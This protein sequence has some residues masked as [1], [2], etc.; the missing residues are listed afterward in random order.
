MIEPIKPL[1]LIKIEYYHVR[2]IRKNISD[3]LLELDLNESVLVENIVH[4]YINGDK[5]FCNNTVVDPFDIEA[6]KINRTAVPP[7]LLLLG[8]RNRREAQRRSSRV[9]IVGIPDEWYV[10]EEG[11]HVTRQFIKTPP[12]HSATLNQKQ[13]TV[14]DTKKVFIVHGP[15]DAAKLE[16][17]RIIEG[18]RLKPIILHEQA[19][20]G[21]TLIEKFEKRIE[22]IGYAFILL[23]PDDI[24]KD[25]TAEMYRARQNV[26]LELGYFMGKLGRDRVCYIYKDGVELPSD[27]HGVAY[28]SFSKKVK[29]CFEDIMRELKNAGYHLTV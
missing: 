14:L 17:A 4:P 2:I 19:N 15:D 29:E 11:E 5:F 6:I 22:N 13:S 28:A 24:C 18:F 12:K 7:G 8:I 26:I 21:K 3:D 9:A 20:G 27:I 23:T 25:K 16:L 10:T 1:V